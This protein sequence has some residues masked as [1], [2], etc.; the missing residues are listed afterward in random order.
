[1]AECLVPWDKMGE[2]K[3]RGV[4]VVTIFFFSEFSTEESDSLLSAAPEK[5]GQCLCRELH[6]WRQKSSPLKTRV[7]KESTNPRGSAD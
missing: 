7:G 3:K 4:E 2:K 5:Q 6:L 1:M